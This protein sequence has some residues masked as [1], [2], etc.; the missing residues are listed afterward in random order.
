MSLNIKNDVTDEE[1]W[2]ILYANLPESK[3]ASNVEVQLCLCKYPTPYT[4]SE[5]VICEEC[6]I[7]LERHIM[8]EKSD[9][10][11]FSTEDG[12]GPKS[13]ERTG[14]TYD[15]LLPVS[16][17]ST[18]INGDSKMSKINMWSSIPYN[19]KV[20]I[21]L[22]KQLNDIV[23]VNNLPTSIVY[24]TLVMFKKILVNKK[25]NG[26]KEI[27]R[28]RIKDGLIAFCMF[29]TSN[30]LGI[31]LILSKIL[32]FFKIDKKT[33]NKCSKIYYDSI[34]VEQLDV[35]VQDI[36]IRICNQLQLPFKVQVL[37]K[38]I[39]KVV[40]S[41]HIFDRYAPQSI[42]SSLVYFINKELGYTDN[43]DQVHGAS[44]VSKSTILKIYKVLYENKIK[45]FN[46]VKG[47]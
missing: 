46:S 47:T 38:K 39:F 2:D 22:K 36:F 14:G 4:T 6:G 26:C 29:Y 1:I 32:D 25:S 35:T 16:S 27:H 8:S 30:T 21:L 17:M 24:N 18:I 13:M 3:T 7:V 11:N 41:M 23:L 33:F 5:S 20:I 9:S 42:A 40:D 44:G 28:G 31:N 34:G 45:I 15:D 10:K 43:I 19:E 12:T 37:C